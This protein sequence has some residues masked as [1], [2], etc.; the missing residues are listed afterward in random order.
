MSIEANRRTE[1]EPA[2]L[3]SLDVP[4]G[5]PAASDYPDYLQELRKI[6]DAELERRLRFSNDCPKRLADAMGYSLLAPGKRLRPALAM[7][8]FE[9][10]GGERLDD[11][12]P[13]CVALEAVHAYSLIHDD[14]PAM[15]DDALRRGRPTCHRKFDEATAILAGDALL[16]FAFDV[17]GDGTKNPSTSLS[18]VKILA[19]AAG[20]TGMVGGQT[21]DVLWAS[22]LKDGV[23]ARDLIGETLAVAADEEQDE[24]LSTSDDPRISGLSLFLKK[25]HRRKTGA[26]FGA[27]VEL[28]ALFAGADAKTLGA[29]RSYGIDLGLA[30]QIADDLLDEVGDEA[31]L[32][33]SVHKDADA[34][35]LTFP[36]LYG[37]EA[38]REKLAAVVARA[39]SSLLEMA[40]RF[41]RRPRAFNALLYLVDFAAGREK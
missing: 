12:A 27:A 38:T 5:F 23:G 14:L 8:A 15:D 18:A 33:K 39:K 22:T 9:A 2:P 10:C 1:L 31:T 32:G 30:F 34:D 3:A 16:T 17:L 28:G 25:I 35:K 29:L 20:A 26:L 21:D 11:V 4:A 6:A 19:S 24:L 13:V 7:I 36:A 41:K 37:I 40:G